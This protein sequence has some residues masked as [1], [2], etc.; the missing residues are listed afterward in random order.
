M[1]WTVQLLHVEWRKAVEICEAEGRR[2]AESSC[3]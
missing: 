1:D 3:S 2:D